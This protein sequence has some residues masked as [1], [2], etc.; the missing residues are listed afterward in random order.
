MTIFK[1]YI[2]SRVHTMKRPWLLIQIPTYLIF[3]LGLV[4]V[5]FWWGMT[6]FLMGCVHQMG[7]QYRDKVLEDRS[8]RVFVRGDV[9]ISVK[10]RPSSLADTFVR[11]GWTEIENF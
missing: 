2:V 10:T 6:I 3:L 1:S 4:Y 8:F 5:N 11:E 7:Y 9:T